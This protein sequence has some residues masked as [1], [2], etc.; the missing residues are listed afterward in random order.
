MVP[1]LREE[2]ERRKISVATLVNGLMEAIVIDQ[3]FNAILDE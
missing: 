2:A 3:M 1:G